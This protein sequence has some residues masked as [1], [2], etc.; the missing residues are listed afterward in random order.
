MN[1]TVNIKPFV[2]KGFFDPI[3]VEQVFRDVNPEDKVKDKQTIQ[4]IESLNQRFEDNVG[5]LDVE[6]EEIIE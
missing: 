4:W 3:L 2:K 1:K 6:P 5:K